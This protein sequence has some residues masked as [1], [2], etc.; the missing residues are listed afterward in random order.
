MAPDTIVRF[1]KD[2][3][4]SEGTLYRDEI[5]PYTANKTTAFKAGTVVT[6]DNWY[7]KSGTLKNDTVLPT[8][9]STTQDCKANSQVT[10]DSS[11]YVISVINP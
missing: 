4:V 9:E 3:Y 1:E 6:F 7:V 5:L 10:F 11:G 8:S 2:G